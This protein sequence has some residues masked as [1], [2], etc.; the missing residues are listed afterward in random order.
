MYHVVWPPG[1]APVVFL[2]TGLFGFTP[3]GTEPAAFFGFGPFGVTPG[4]LGFGSDDEGSSES[5]P[6]GCSSLRSILGGSGSSLGCSVRSSGSSPRS[7]VCFCELSFLLSFLL[8]DFCHL[9]PLFL[10][11]CFLAGLGSIGLFGCLGGFSGPSKVGEGFCCTA[12]IH[13]SLTVG[14]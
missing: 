10:A 1:V 11:T 5:V 8:S 3:F 7:S 6:G 4:F 12:L 14:I 9:A 2:G 13:S